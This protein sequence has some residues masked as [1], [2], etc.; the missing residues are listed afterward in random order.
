MVRRL[1]LTGPQRLVIRIIGRF[2]SIYHK[3]LSD[4]LHVHPSSLTALLKRLERRDLISRRS[5]GRDRSGRPANASRQRDRSDDLTPA[6]SFESRA[7]ARPQ[8]SSI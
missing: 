5:D 2:P 1:G 4:I 6:E 3:Q 7:M 8:V